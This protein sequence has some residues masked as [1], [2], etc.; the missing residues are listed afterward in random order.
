MN[1][2]EKKIYEAQLLDGV[3][4]N[5]QEL[6]ESKT[7]K[8]TIVIMISMSF[9]NDG[10]H[11]TLALSENNNINKAIKQVHCSMMLDRAQKMLQEGWP[12]K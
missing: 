10:S 11:T 5:S 1:S 3:A 2:D 8:A 12:V 9:D 6:L 7:G 4:N